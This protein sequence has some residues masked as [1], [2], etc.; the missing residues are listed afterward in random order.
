MKS[1][2]PPAIWAWTILIVVASFLSWGT[3]RP[4]TFS[5]FPSG[6]PGGFPGIFP[7][8]MFQNM[9]I[10]V[11]GWNGHLTLGAQL[12]NW[13]AVVAALCA[14][15]TIYLQSTGAQLSPR[16]APFLLLYS[17]CHVAVLSLILL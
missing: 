10:S 13:L 11:N 15:L 2:F 4:T 8:E 7:G 17:F 12:P 14:T 3:L 6:F 5:G 1:T 9:R 16:L